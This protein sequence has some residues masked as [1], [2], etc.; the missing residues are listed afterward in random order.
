[1]TLTN[2]PHKYIKNNTLVKDHTEIGISKYYKVIS[3]TNNKRHYID[4]L[5][6]SRINDLISVIYLIV[7]YIKIILRHKICIEEIDHKNKQEAQSMERGYMS[8]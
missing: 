5:H 8:I 3:T 6:T 1:M 2:F 7:Y 4:I